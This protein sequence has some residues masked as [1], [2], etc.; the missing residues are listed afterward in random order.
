MIDSSVVSEFRLQYRGTL[1]PIRV[2]EL[3]LGRSSYASIVINN[4]LASR[5][6]ALIRFV[7]GRL[8]VV[9]LGSKNGTTVNGR[10]IEGACV[11]DAGDQVKIGTDVIDIVRVSHQDPQ[12]LRAPTY[13]G[14][15]VG[16][17]AEEGE[18]TVHLRRSLELAEALMSACTSEAQ[19]PAT[20]DVVE[21]VLTEFLTQT[22]PSALDDAALHRIRLVMDTVGSWNLGARVDA[23]RQQLAARLVP[24][25]V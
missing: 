2:G 11:I 23:W 3:T 8:E 6:H 24:T 16:A 22:P 9:D 7:G 12:E 18:T 5:E 13:P 4:P 21:Q 17:P 14:R 25:G 10:R 20:A 1:F 15:G 19:R